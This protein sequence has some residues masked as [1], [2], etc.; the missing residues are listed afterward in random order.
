MK[1][2]IIGQR[3]RR[4]R[5]LIGVS[6]Q[7]I[8]KRYNISANTIK[9][10]ETG[11]SEIGIIRLAKYL[12]VFKEYGISISIDNILDLELN[13]YLDEVTPLNINDS[14]YN[15]SE[16]EAFR[17]LENAK[18]LQLISDTITS[19]VGL[20]LEKKEEM[21][22]ALFDNLPLRILFKDENNVILRLNNL[23]AKGLGGVVD[24]FEGKSVY[25]LFPKIA[26]KCHEEDLEALRNNVPM[27]V[28]E[29]FVA[30][31]STPV[32]ISIN[33]IPIYGQN[34]KMVLTIFRSLN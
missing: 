9:V 32:M 11:K 4:A 16:Q 6:R 8:E 22:R 7:E 20:V 5:K 27:I 25:D 15:L 10:W 29:E 28:F 23:A 14:N 31:K 17:N 26:K 3:L 24:D 21:L 30:L 34:R 18:E 1:L 12:C 13:N 2:D 33:K 19:T